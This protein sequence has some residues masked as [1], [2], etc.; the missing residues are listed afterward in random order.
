VGYL[1]GRRRCAR[2]RKPRREIVTSNRLVA[3]Y[4]T[5]AVVAVGSAA[6]VGVAPHP[7]DLPGARRKSPPAPT[8]H[9]AAAEECDGGELGAAATGGAGGGGGAAPPFFVEAMLSLTLFC[10]IGTIVDMTTYIEVQKQN[11]RVELRWRHD[12]TCARDLIERHRGLHGRIP[13]GGQHLIGRSQ[14]LPP[15]S[16]TIKRQRP[17]QPPSSRRRASKKMRPG[18]DGC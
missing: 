2:S 6:L 13:P 15:P 1:G 3:Q 5:L 8:G 18:I 10:L 7:E 12:L 14:L 17:Q 16:M 9:A 11:G 4:F